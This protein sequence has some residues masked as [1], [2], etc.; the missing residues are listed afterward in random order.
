MAWRFKASKYKNA[1]PL[2]PKLE[3]QVRGLSVGDYRGRGNLVA[4][5]A[6][7][8]AFN[9]ELQGSSL[10]VLPLDFKGRLARTTAPLVHAHSDFVTDFQFSVMK[11]TNYA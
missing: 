6:A 7:F 2:A 11:S 10:C 5:S 1:A 8:L 3:E 9:W 4:S